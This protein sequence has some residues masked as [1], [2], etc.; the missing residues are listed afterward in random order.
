MAED[1]LNLV[2]N[3]EETIKE[4]FGFNKEDTV[5]VNKY[6]ELFN[7]ATKIAN[8]LVD[9]SVNIKAQDDNREAV[10]N[11]GVDL[12]KTAARKSA[13]LKEP[14]KKLFER[15]SDGGGVANALISLKMQVEYLDPGQLDFKAG[16][17][18]R[19]VGRMP[20][21]GDSL[22]RYFSRFES[23]QTI[24]DAVIRSLEDGREQLK[25]D[26]KTLSQDQRDMRET[27]MR[28]EKIIYLGRILDQKLKERLQDFTSENAKHKFIQEELLF[29]LRQR[30]MDLQQQLLV[31]QQGV[32]TME[33]IIRNN[34][35]LIRGVNRALNVTVTAL[36]IA[37]A[38]ALALN[39]QKIVLDKINI[40]NA[41]T[42]SLISSTAKRLKTQG[43]EVYKIASSTQL[44]KDTLQA[45]FED[46]K[47]AI[48]DISKFRQEALPKMAEAVLTMNKR[49]ESIGDEI[50]KIE[51]GNKLAPKIVIDFEGEE[52]ENSKED[53]KNL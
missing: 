38:V 25:R 48:D 21:A 32:V 17:V 10:E 45:A 37:V 47:A 50:R 44:D 53:L 43:V 39:D 6:P 49:T 9:S 13:M 26:S 30:I 23:A 31:N 29:P 35:E 41:T 1:K 16:W 8:A 40:L 5:D 20:F 7:K 2:I 19:I 27:T 14:V 28:L 24:I 18:N 33:I 42:N 12:Q 15:S 36:E 3:D 34:K 4:E 51:E 46:I 52:I 22:K 11:M